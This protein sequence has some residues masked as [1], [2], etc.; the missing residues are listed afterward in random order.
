M[1]SVICVLRLRIDLTRLDSYYVS[2]HYCHKNL[3]A[4]EILPTIFFLDKAWGRRMEYLARE[5]EEV[6]HAFSWLSTLGGA[7]SALG[8]NYGHCAVMAGKISWAQLRLAIRMGDP[9]MKSRCYLFLAISIAQ[10]GHLKKAK[11]IV[12][13]VKKSQP[14]LVS[15]C[16]GVSAHF[17]RLKMT[18]S[19][20]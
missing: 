8:D 16:Q 18:R 17:Y 5:R 10:Q 7:F 19:G 13:L 6:E 11:N 20:S 3:L 14:C 12:R 4:F 1:R 9:I 2:R 15:I